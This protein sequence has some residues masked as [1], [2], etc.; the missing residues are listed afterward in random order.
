MMK[1]KVINSKYQRTRLPVVGTVFWL[2]LLHYYSAP[3]W[4]WGVVITLLAIVWPFIIF[5]VFTEQEVHPSEVDK[6]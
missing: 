4:L 3:G 2:F 5:M 6:R 1:R